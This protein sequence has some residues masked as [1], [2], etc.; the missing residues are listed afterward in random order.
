M[1]NSI[2]RISSYKAGYDNFSSDLR[3]KID[4]VKTLKSEIS[5]PIVLE[6]D[7]FNY[8]DAEPNGEKGFFGVLGSIALIAVASFA[9]ARK[10]YNK[11]TN[12]FKGEIAQ[13]FLNNEKVQKAL[14]VIKT[15]GASAKDAIV[16]KIP[17]KVKSNKAVDFLKS[18]KVANA[19][20]GFKPAT[21]VGL[22]GAA[23]GTLAASTIDGDEDGLP[24]MIEKNIS[25]LDSISDKVGGVIDAVRILS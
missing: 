17:E 5:K 14:D 22:A 18:N 15:K 4:A 12:F 19:V 7:E 21:K 23:A 9:L 25:I 10:G 1:E 6:N 24:D 16:N 20:K 2:D 13:K 3:R 11:V 8:S